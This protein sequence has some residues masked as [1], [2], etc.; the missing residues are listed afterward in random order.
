MFT[1]ATG[2]PLCPVGRATS[3]RSSSSSSSNLTIGFDFRSTALVTGDD[4]RAAS[5]MGT[6]SSLNVGSSSWS[7]EVFAAGGVAGMYESGS[8]VRFVFALSRFPDIG[9]DRTR[10]FLRA[11]VLMGCMRGAEWRGLFVLISPSR[12]S[13]KSLSAALATG[14]T[15]Q[16]RSTTLAIQVRLESPLVLEPLQLSS[17]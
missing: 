12:S 1:L 15:S 8:L 7:V 17:R 4:G 5:L 13:M 9:G 2:T 11:S 10:V 16:S 14:C 6:S 3:I